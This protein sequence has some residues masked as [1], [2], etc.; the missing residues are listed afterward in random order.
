MV[1][2]EVLKGLARLYL[3]ELVFVLPSSSCNLEQNPRNINGTL[4]HT[5]N[6]ELEIFYATGH[7]FASLC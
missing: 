5:P 7:L 4:L 3:S 2:F 6:F 1:A